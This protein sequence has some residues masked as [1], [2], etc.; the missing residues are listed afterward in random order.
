ML[1]SSAAVLAI[2]AIL[3][4]I[5]TAHAKDVKPVESKGCP[6]SLKAEITE[7]AISKIS[8]LAPSPKQAL[9]DPLAT[10]DRDDTIAES[11]GNRASTPRPTSRRRRRRSRPRATPSSSRA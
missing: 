10:Y 7:G 5:P 4:A 3:A 8:I 11:Y 9:A 6:S 2:T 1:R